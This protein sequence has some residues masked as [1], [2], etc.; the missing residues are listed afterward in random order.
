MQTG[1]VSI[2]GGPF[3][4][5]H[6]SDVISA[7]KLFSYGNT[8]LPLIKN[9][10]MWNWGDNQM[11]AGQ[12]VEYIIPRPV[13]ILLDPDETDGICN[14]LGEQVTGLS[15]ALQKSVTYEVVQHRKKWKK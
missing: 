4:T 10:T 8:V 2:S 5:A 9:Q 3:H 7:F 15:N 11:G 12:G 13:F 6:R 14:T 1:N